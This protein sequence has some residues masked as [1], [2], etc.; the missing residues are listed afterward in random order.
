MAEKTYLMYNSIHLRSGVTMYYGV[1]NPDYPG[2]NLEQLTTLKEWRGASTSHAIVIDAGAAVAVDTLA[3][4]GNNVTRNL[5][6]TSVV[7]QA[8]SSDSWGSPA[9]SVTMAS[10]DID[11]DNQFGLKTFSSTQTYRYWRLTFANTTAGATYA[12]ISKMFLGLRTE[13]SVD[14]GWSMGLQSRDE[15]F[16]GLYGQTW[17]N[18]RNQQKLLSLPFT[19]LNKTEMEALVTI[20]R[21]CRQSKPLWVC[22]DPSEGIATKRELFAG[23]FRLASFPQITNDSYGLFSMSMDLQEIV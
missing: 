19:V 17:V 8:N 7:V 21:F 18:E 23:Y 3:I 10:T 13:V 5:A 6:C 4:C 15:M 9:F 20:G 22:L 11:Q 2:A 1:E 16:E 14:L 12:G